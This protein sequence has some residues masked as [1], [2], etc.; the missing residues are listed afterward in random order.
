MGIFPDKLIHTYENVI[1]WLDLR[2]AERAQGLGTRFPF[3]PEHIIESLSDSTIYMAFYTIYHILAKAGAK[4]ENLTDSLFDYVYLSKG[5]AAE[6]ASETGLDEMTVKECK[7]SFDYWYGLSSSHSGSDLVN[8]HLVMYVFNHVAVFPEKIWPKQIVTNGI[9]KYEGEKMSKSMGNVIPLKDALVKYGAD[10]LR[11]ALVAG[12]DLDTD[13]EFSETQIGGIK[14]RNEY[15]YSIMFDLDSFGSKELGQLDFWLYS[16]L[17]SKIVTATAL[18]NKIMMKGAYNEIY[19]SSVSEI[20]RYI[21]M[22][23]KNGLVLEEYMSA[24]ARM[25]YPVMPHIA[26]ELWHTLGKNT[27]VAREEWP[28]PDESMINPELEKSYDAVESILQDISNAVSLMSNMPANKGKSVKGIKIIVASAWKFD[29]YDMLAEKKSISAVIEAMHDI[30]KE[31]LAKYLAQFKKPSDYVDKIGIKHD[32][33]FSVLSSSLGYVSA[34]ANAIVYVESED[35]S[36]SARAARALPL[37][38][39]LDLTWG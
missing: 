16:K 2:A 15:L 17:N 14:S 12:A 29:A 4:P 33:L 37:K 11:M 32:T 8:N 28:V 26:E 23:G 1:D 10:P 3:N 31:K 39:S 35:V 9:V 21:D 25:L 20:K 36:K 24:V 22:G 38:P 30:D 13:V 27:L 34:K 6:V 5:A 19:Y 18:M 7:D